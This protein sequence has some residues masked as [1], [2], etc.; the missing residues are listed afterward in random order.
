M[1]AARR[2]RRRLSVDDFDALIASGR[3]AGAPVELIDGW[4]YDMNAQGPIH[5]NHTVWLRQVL[6]G[7]YGPGHYVRDHS[8]L[9]ATDFDQPEPDLALVRGEPAKGERPHP[10]GADVVLVME[11]SVTTL[12]ED[13]EKAAV[14]ARG[15]VPE[16][17]LVAPHEG[18]V[19]VHRGPNPDGSYREKLTYVAGDAIPWPERDDAVDAAE[20]L[21]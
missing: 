8:P 20:L 13:R 3:L 6:E 1:T 12:A 7:A 5:A 17:W 21:P 19:E 11:L 18:Q 15:G 4:L 14:Y 2:T 9:R 10:T 16:Y